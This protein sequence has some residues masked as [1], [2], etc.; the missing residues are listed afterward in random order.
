MGVLKTFSSSALLFQGLRG[1][2]LSSQ[3][4]QKGKER[5][6]R[7]N[8]EREHMGRIALVGQGGVIPATDLLRARLVASARKTTSAPR[9]ILESSNWRAGDTAQQLRVHDALPGDLRSGPSSCIRWLTPVCN[10]RSSVCFRPWSW[11][12]TCIH[13][14]TDTQLPM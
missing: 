12:V 8:C 3:S 14:P 13:P 11:T 7:E 6:G 10:S 1:H 2:L 5:K 9:R 4:K